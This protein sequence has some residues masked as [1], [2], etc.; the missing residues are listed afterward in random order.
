M[1]ADQILLM[2]I[3]VAYLCGSIP[4]GLIVGKA[5]GIDPRTA[6]S[7]NIGATNL[8]RLL[9]AKFFALVFTLDLLKGAVPTLVAG[10]VIGFRVDDRQTGLLWMIVGAFA[11]IGHVCSVFLKFKGGKG[12]ATSAGVVLGV[13]P[14][15]TFA[16][17]AA[18]AVFY[19][20]FRLTKFI[21]VGSMVGAASFPAAYIAVG[22]G[23]WPITGAQLPLLCFAIFFPLLLIFKHRTNISRL[24]AGTEPH[25]SPKTTC[26]SK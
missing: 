25:Y 19:I 4:F 6:G 10:A 1:T 14:Y 9:G 24:L 5:K 11:V 15:F 21:S 16:A 22:I 3:P 13:F 20:V 26:E 18:L 17:I 8:G 12:V 7:G 23:R 2:L